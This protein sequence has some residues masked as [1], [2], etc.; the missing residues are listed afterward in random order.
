[1]AKALQEYSEGLWC[2]IQGKILTVGVTEEALNNIESILNYH[3]PEEGQIVECEEMI[4][5]LAGNQDSISIYSPVSGQILEV[6]ETIIEN[7]H[8]IYEDPL[9]ESWLF[10]V[11]ADDEEEIEAIFEEKILVET[12]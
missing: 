3:I 11:E 7:P 9:G 6:N 12:D 4:G 10:K 2:T 8:L 1:M 5:E